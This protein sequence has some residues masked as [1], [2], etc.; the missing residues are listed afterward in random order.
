[1]S[2]GLLVASSVCL[3][4]SFM[5]QVA[6]RGDPVP[7]YQSDAQANAYL[8]SG[9]HERAMGR[10]KVSRQLMTCCVIFFGLAVCAMAVSP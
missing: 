7:D 3:A 8:S 1:M 6:G 10:L 9:K 2:G 4:L 5:L